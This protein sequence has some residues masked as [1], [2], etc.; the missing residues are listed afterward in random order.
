MRIKRMKQILWL[1]WVLVGLGLEIWALADRHPG[2]TLSETVWE[3]TRKYPLL[4]LGFG[5]L[6]GHFFWQS[7]K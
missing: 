1:V 7:A 4:P 6:A 3:I 2:N 5:L